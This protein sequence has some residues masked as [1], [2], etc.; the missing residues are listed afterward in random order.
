MRTKK[1]Q[2]PDRMVLGYLLRYK[3][4]SRHR[5]YTHFDVVD[6]PKIIFRLKK[7]LGYKF[8]KKGEGKELTYTLATEAISNAQH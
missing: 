8:T 1:K 2:S 7:K 4:I 5:A 3:A 6:L